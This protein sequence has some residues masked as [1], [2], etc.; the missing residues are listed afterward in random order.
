MPE[1]G[2]LLGVIRR[3]FKDDGVTDAAAGMTYYGLMALAPTILLGVSLAVLIGQNGLRRE[4]TE[5]LQDASPSLAENVEPIIDSA[6][7]NQGGALAA[8]IIA[9]IIAINGASGAYA[10]AGRGLARIYGV[11]DGRGL[12]LGRA[13]AAAW[14]VLL[15]V[16]LLATFILLALGG[17]FADDTLRFVGLGSTGVMI[18]SIVR[19]PLAV[20]IAML[21]FALL[22]RYAPGDGNRR[23]RLVTP[24]SAFGVVLW[25]LATVGFFIY[26]RTAAT[27]SEAYGSVAGIVILLIWMW[28]SNLSLLLGA[29]LDASLDELHEP[30]RAANG[31]AAV[32]IRSETG[33]PPAPKAPAA[34]SPETRRSST[35]VRAPAAAAVV[36][37]IAG[38]FARRR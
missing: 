21:V 36:G 19:F 22:Y 32:E 30:A 11:R 1:T 13:V 25:F 10:A 2:A 14:T 7:R 6:F 16:L 18:W 20:L 12:L 31:E 23:F 26:V 28:L 35:P 17:A 4:I 8:T 5:R 37:F 24:G 34:V 15:L 9:I 33:Q 29:L 27:Y 3:R 38:W